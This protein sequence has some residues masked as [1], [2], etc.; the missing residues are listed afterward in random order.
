MHASRFPK[1]GNSMFPADR[2][3]PQPTGFKT[4]TPRTS[5][6]TLALAF[7]A[8]AFLPTTIRAQNFTFPSFTSNAGLQVNGNAA[9]DQT[10]QDGTSKVLRLTPAQVDQAGSAFSTNAIHLGSNA[11][12]RRRSPSRCGT[13]AASA[14]ARATRSALTESYLS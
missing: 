3:N 12:F 1:S 13:A 9:T 11:S 5:G 14:T 10:S 7:S 6:Y 8:T 4:M 2:P